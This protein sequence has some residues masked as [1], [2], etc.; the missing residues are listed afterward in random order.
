[1]NK[2]I[3]PAVAEHVM[4]ENAR[5][6][7][8][9][10]WIADYAFG[11]NGNEAAQRARAALSQQAEPAP[12]QS[13]K[14]DPRTAAELSVAGC[15]C[16]R[17]GEGNPHWPCRIHAAPAQDEREA[18][19]AR[20]V[21][22]AG[23]GAADLWIK[24]SPGA[25]YSNERVNDHRFGW[26]ACLEWMAT[27]PA[28]TDPQGL[29]IVLDGPPEAGRFV[30]IADSDG[31]SVDAGEWRERTDGLWEMVLHPAVP[32][33]ELVMPVALGSVNADYDKGWADHAEEVVRLNATPSQPAESE[34]V[35]VAGFLYKNNGQALTAADMDADTFAL[36][37]RSD[38]DGDV[39]KLVRQTDHTAA[40]SAVTAERD[41]EAESCEQWRAL[42]L[43]FD[44]HRM[45]AL[46]HLKMVV[47]G[48]EGA[49]DACRDFLSAPPVPGHAIT[50]DVDQLRAE[51]EALRNEAASEPN[52]YRAVVHALRRAADGQRFG[53]AK[54]QR[55]FLLG[56]NSAVRLIEEMAR[57]GDIV[58]DE[59]AGEEGWAYKFPDAAMA[60]KEA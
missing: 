24:G 5:L 55:T 33:P 59:G 28:Q 9:L 38:F 19:E 20:M 11:D 47:A 50:E 40:L 4:E 58:P 14:D 35:E 10:Q 43:Q 49:L 57:R 6:R 53:A 16:V 29:R 12:S 46:A 56:Y 37:A 17:F 60:A 13:Y 8:A 21:L 2:P 31:C 7:E 18:F 15:R 27:R 52:I 44:R 36:M 25:G 1:M 45:S 22:E 48:Q 54:V 51:V 34:G 41:G 23:P 3:H 26:V 42:A 32:Q 30:E 39:E